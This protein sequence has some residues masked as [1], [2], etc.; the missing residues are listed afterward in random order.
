[1]EFFEDQRKNIAMHNGSCV[2]EDRSNGC[3]KFNFDITGIN[4]NL[5]L[6]GIN[7]NL[8]LIKNRKQFILY[9]WSNKCSH[10]KHKTFLSKH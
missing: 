9:F 1:M 2:N 10:G 3:W 5:Q 4:T 7:T 8:Q 6:T